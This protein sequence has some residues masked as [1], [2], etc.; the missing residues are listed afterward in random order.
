MTPE[1]GIQDAELII[2]DEA[3]LE[4]SAPRARNLK[5]ETYLML[6]HTLC[7]RVTDIATHG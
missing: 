5:A 1:F 4:K 2:H 7:F 3:V 6:H